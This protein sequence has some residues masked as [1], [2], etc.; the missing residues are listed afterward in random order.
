MNGLDA[1]EHIRSQDATRDLPIVMISAY[2]G[3]E[4]EARCSAIGVN[5]FLPKPIT[6]SSLFD[7]IIEA[8]GVNTH[9]PP[10]AAVTPLEMEF[11]GVRALLAED[12]ETNQMVATELLS[13][14]GIELD[15]A[16][17]GRKAVAMARE[18][19][20]RYA[21]ILMDMQMPEMD[22]LEATRVLRADPEFRNLPIIAMTA[23][24][25]R[26]DLEACLAAGMNDHIV[27][28]IDRGVM[29]AT[30]RRWLPRNAAVEA[31]PAI[32]KGD[33]V[34]E[35]SQANPAVPEVTSRLPVLEGVE[36]ETALKRLGLPFE[37]LRKMLIR[38]ADAQK[39]TLENIRAAVLANDSAAAAAQAHA[40]AGAAG[41]LGAD[42]LRE[43]AKALEKVGREGQTNL[44]ELLSVV[45]QR[46]KWSSTP[47]SY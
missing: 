45:E 18:H 9:I 36:I 1:A 26:Q 4:E 33:A 37:S 25:M 10:K 12:N 6:A 46:R 17:N 27:K 13:R 11:A 23:N 47:S 3:K 44:G 15:I 40:L 22:G 14:L 30:L 32:Q 20:G 38:F 41:N 42:K 35:T 21:A 29:A 28:P 16:D 2:A 31:G 7:A 39:K 19:K 8:Q 43:A 5:V 34:S 24:A